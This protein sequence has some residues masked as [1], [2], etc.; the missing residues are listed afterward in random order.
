[1]QVISL[2]IG[3]VLY[4]ASPITLIPGKSMAYF[5][6]VSRLPKHVGAVLIND[7]CVGYMQAQKS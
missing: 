7:Q 5:A 2:R 1:M 3:P 4:D 6:D